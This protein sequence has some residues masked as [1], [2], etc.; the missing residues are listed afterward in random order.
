MLELR[1]KGGALD[2][3]Q[4]ELFKIQDD[5]REVKANEEECRHQMH[6]MSV[7]IDERDETIE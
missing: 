2:Y 5:L 6:T 7:Q 3:L 4:R 1:Q